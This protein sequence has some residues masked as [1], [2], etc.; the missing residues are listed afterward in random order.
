MISDVSVTVRKHLLGCVLNSCSVKTKAAIASRPL[1]LH[2][3]FYYF[4]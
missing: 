4:Y 3:Y 1:H 2:D